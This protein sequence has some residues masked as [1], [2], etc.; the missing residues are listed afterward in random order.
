MSVQCNRIEKAL[1]IYLTFAFCQQRKA[2]SNSTNF[3]HFGYEIPDFKLQKTLSTNLSNI[4]HFDVQIRLSIAKYFAQFGSSFKFRRRASNSTAINDDSRIVWPLN[5]FP[6][7][8]KALNFEVQNCYT[9]L[10][11]KH[12]NF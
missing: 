4:S 12:S 10:I 11:R 7:K 3:R 2:A 6:R 8:A 9:S 1:L 5:G